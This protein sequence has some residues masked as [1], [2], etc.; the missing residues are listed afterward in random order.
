MTYPLPLGE[1]DNHLSY[2]LSIVGEGFY[3]IHHDIFSLRRN[4]TG[5]AGAPLE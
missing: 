3:T 2:P 5:L 1:G 4:E